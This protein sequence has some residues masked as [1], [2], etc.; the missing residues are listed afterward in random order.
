MPDHV[1]IGH[2]AD[3]DVPLF[4]PRSVFG[5]KRFKVTESQGAE[6]FFHNH[7][8]RFVQ[9][10]G[11]GQFRLRN[12]RLDRR[13][14]TPSRGLRR[15]PHLGEDLAND[16]VDIEGV[17]SHSLVPLARSIFRCRCGMA[18]TIPYGNRAPRP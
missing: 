12:L 14:G 10:R 1:W 18:R 3:D 5:R 6:A 8:R 7:Q 4:A 16:A 11:D 9:R 17:R 15:Q 2:A 13:G